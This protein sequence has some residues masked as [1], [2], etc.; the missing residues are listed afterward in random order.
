MFNG[1]HSNCFTVMLTVYSVLCA[2]FMY[3]LG[4]LQIPLPFL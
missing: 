4:S 3:I 2:V 1:G